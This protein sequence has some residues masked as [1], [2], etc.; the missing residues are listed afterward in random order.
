MCD[1]IFFSADHNRQGPSFFG[2]NSD[3]KP[4]EPQYFQLVPE[5]K[6]KAFSIISGGRRAEVPDLGLAY[7]VSRPSWM[8]GAEMGINSAGVAIGNEAVFGRAPLDKKGILG[9]DILRLALQAARTAEEAARFIIGFIEEFGQGGNGAY[10]GKL[11][12]HNSFLISDPKEAYVLETAGKRWALKKSPGLS[13]ISNAYSIENSFTEADPVTAKA[14]AAGGSWKQ[15]VEKGLFT[16]FSRG[17]IRGRISREFLKNLSGAV[18]LEDIFSL[19]RNHGNYSPKRKN[20]KNMESLCIH[21]GG[22][23]DNATTASMVVEYPGKSGGQDKKPIVAWFTGT[24]CP[25]ISLYKPVILQDG[26]FMPLWR[27]YGY[28]ENSPDR[29]G[30]WSSQYRRLLGKAGSLSLDTDFRE[31]RDSLQLKLIKAVEEYVS[32]DKEKAAETVSD[33]VSS[34]EALFK[35]VSS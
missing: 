11:Y 14:L 24:S 12:Y 21:S 30:Y 22:L 28:D 4:A 13:A 27:D 17:N 29:G 3:R 35:T 26:R 23:L 33:S 31:K 5:R 19:L 10:K 16:Y 32:G 18:Q 34:F 1:T 6:P 2:K 9:M 8:W 25:C 7:A 20:R 15:A